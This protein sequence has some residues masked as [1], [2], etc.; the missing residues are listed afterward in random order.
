MWQYQLAKR[1]FLSK[2]AM[3][4]IELGQ[5]TPDDATLCRL[6]KALHCK[7]LLLARCEECVTGKALTEIEVK[8]QVA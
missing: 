1:A 2:S 3:S 7:G 6:A 4:R 8:K 5:V